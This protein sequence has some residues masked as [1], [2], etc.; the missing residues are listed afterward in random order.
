MVH[1]PKLY[2]DNNTLVSYEEYKKGVENGTIFN[3]LC[4]KCNTI[5]PLT[6]FNKI[7]THC[8]DCVSIHN[9]N[10]YHLNRDEFKKRYY[11]YNKIDRPFKPRGR[12]VN[13][14]N[15][16]ERKTEEINSYRSP[17]TS[18]QEVQEKDS[19]NIVSNGDA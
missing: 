13:G 5:K 18:H 14:N 12:H 2:N 3:K 6:E 15:T 9:A 16:G 17:E 4:K 1:Y 8:K 10:T 19:E 7:P 11:K